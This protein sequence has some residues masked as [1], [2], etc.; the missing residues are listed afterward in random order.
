MKCSNCSTACRTNEP[1]RYRWCPDCKSAYSMR[2]GELVGKHGD[3]A[4]IHAAL[5][6]VE[7]KFRTTKFGVMDRW[8]AWAKTIPGKATRLPPADS[9]RITELAAECRRL[10]GDVSAAATIDDISQAD[11]R[12][13]ACAESA[14]DWMRNSVF[15]VLERWSTIARAYATTLPTIDAAKLI[16]WANDVD[17]LAV[18]FAFACTDDDFDRFNKKYEELGQFAEIVALEIDR[19]IMDNPQ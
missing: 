6:A 9:V 14:Q 17:R 4:D 19:S 3:Y 5:V 15:D 8:E 16:E 7:A 1:R 13:K 10:I 12:L 2:T 11:E 18:V